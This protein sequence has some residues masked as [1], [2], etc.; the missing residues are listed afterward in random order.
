MI[1]LA[2]LF[3]AFVLFV[4]FDTDAV[5]EYAQL[6]DLGWIH[7][8]LEN[9]LQVKK[10]GSPQ[11]FLD[12]LAANHDCFTVRLITCPKCSSTWLGGV[13]ALILA[14]FA[15]KAYGALAGFALVSALPYLT[16]FAYKQLKA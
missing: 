10:Q 15:A 12:Y 7:P 4:W 14:P 1:L 9:Y 3:L 11:S 5:V 6:F 16:Y 13:A 8:A 2:A